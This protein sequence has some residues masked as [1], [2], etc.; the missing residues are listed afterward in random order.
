[1][2]IVFFLDYMNDLI[3]GLKEQEQVVI[4]QNKVIELTNDVLAYT[5]TGS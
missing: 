1:M 5:Y 3:D 2:D 4:L